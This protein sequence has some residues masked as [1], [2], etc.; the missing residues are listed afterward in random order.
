MPD[1]PVKLIQLVCP[2]CGPIGEKG[3]TA[4]VPVKRAAKIADNHFFSPSREPELNHDSAWID[5]N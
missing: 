1:K 2:T 4:P 5:A 3:S